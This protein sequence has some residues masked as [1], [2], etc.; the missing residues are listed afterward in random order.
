[1]AK[2]ALT[3]ASGMIGRTVMAALRAG[4]HTVTRLVRSRRA[5]EAPDTIFW[6]PRAGEIDA[7]S[8]EGYD[9]VIHLSGETIQGLWTPAKKRRI[10]DSRVGSTR[11]LSRTLATLRQPPHTLLAASGSNY[12]GDR[13]PTQSM[14]ESGPH[15]TTFLA[16]VCVDNE[17]AADPAREA[18]IRV[19]HFRFAPV[20]SP[21]GGLLKFVLPWFRIGLGATL[22]D[23][24]QLMPWVA[25]PEIPRIV[26]FMLDHPTVSG[27]VNVAA[28]GKT[29]NA[30]FTH[31]LA[32]VLG[33]H[34]V[35]QAPE[36]LIRMFGDLG[37]DLLLETHVV[38]A[39]LDAA[40]YEFAYPELEGAFKAMGV[41]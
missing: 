12:Y 41:G 40:G 19:V 36:L 26:Q 14:D 23:G 11:L 28:P 2:I 38:P 21:E 16:R 1:M 7:V 10:Y 22:G 18:G 34:A 3:A 9:V 5:A 4:G 20:L 32:R 15:G 31:T 13:P 37:E 17:A 24:H 33:R 6:R 25:L 29:T 8:L 27:P 35:L 30:E 39:K